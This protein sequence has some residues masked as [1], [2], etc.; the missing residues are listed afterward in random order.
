MLNARVPRDQ[1]D[2]DRSKIGRDYAAA[3]KDGL[4][5]FLELLRAVGSRLVQPNELF[6]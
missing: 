4:N 1:V 5:Q 2:R 6:Q 3:L